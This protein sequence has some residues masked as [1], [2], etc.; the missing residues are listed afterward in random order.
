M[1]S[2]LILAGFVVAAIGLRTFGHP[3]LRKLG[4][5]LFLVASY[6]F[7]YFLTGSHVAGAA[8]LSI[9]FL[10][11][12]LEIFTRIRKLR[13]PVDKELNHRPPPSANDFPQLNEFTAEIEKEGFEY[14]DDTGWEW[15]GLKQYY[16]L[17]YHPEQKTQAAICLNEQ[18]NMSFA[19]V[20]L[21]SRV[22]A[23]RI[24]RTW[25][26]PFSY[27]MKI[28]PEVRLNRMTNVSSFYNLWE[29]HR[30]FLYRLAIEDGD[31]E[32]IDGSEKMESYIEQETRRQIDHNIDRGLIAMS[33]ESTF[34][35]SWRGLFFLWAQFVKDMVKL[36]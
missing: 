19:Y 28:P 25:N 24:Y 11:P 31:L 26:F 5:V 8:A 30:A 16:R 27:T 9:W 3:I 7:G 13:L 6:L 17:F 12:L 34:R 32:E 10:L 33:D 1:Q 14:V 20:S 4:A 18:Q 35:Y 21:T 2:F 22:N 36:S 29:E 23:E 15:D